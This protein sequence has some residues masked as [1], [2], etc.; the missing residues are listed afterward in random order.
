MCGEA[1]SV[2]VGVGARQGPRGPARLVPGGLLCMSLG[3][4]T[5]WL[6]C[7]DTRVNTLVSNKLPVTVTVTV[8][9]TVSQWRLLK[10]PAQWEIMIRSTAIPQRGMDTD[11]QWL[12]LLFSSLRPPLRLLIWAARSM[13]RPPCHGRRWFSKILKLSWRSPGTVNRSARVSKCKNI[14]S[15][16]WWWEQI[17][18][19][20]DDFLHTEHHN[21]VLGICAYFGSLDETKPCQTPQ[22][23]I[24]CE[25]LTKSNFSKAT[26]HTRTLSYL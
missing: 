26:T 9:V 13:S 12:K 18:S 4:W 14:A 20:R 15:K 23:R 10:Y 21:E 19:V 8:T 5:G 2:V 7:L 11:H 16:P 25:N 1:I 24:H 6:N 22:Y 3:L 17:F